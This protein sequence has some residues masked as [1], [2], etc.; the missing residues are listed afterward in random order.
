MSAL[1]LAIDGQ[2]NKDGQG[3]NIVDHLLD[4]FLATQ[5]EHKDSDLAIVGQF[6]DFAKKYLEDHPPVS[7]FYADIGLGLVL[8]NQ[9]SVVFFAQPV[10][11]TP[12]S[13]VPMT[14]RERSVG[15]PMP[16][17]HHVSVMGD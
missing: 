14:G 17:S 4:E 12:A 9:V 1:D 5:A 11:A 15:G 7:Q 2:L 8:Q 13:Y 10:A 16:S 6:A 3:Q